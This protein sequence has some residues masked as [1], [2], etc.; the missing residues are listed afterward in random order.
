MS[1]HVFRSGRCRQQRAECAPIAAALKR[2][3]NSPARQRSLCFGRRRDDLH[4]LTRSRSCESLATNPDNHR[5]P[6]RVRPMPR[7][8]VDGHVNV[9]DTW[10]D[11]GAPGPKTGARRMLFAHTGSP[12][13]P[14]RP[15]AP[16]VGHQQRSWARLGR[17]QWDELRRPAGERGVLRARSNAV[18]HQGDD[19]CRRSHDSRGACK[20]IHRAPLTNSLVMLIPN[21]GWL[22][23]GS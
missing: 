2:F 16:R 8:V 17:A 6:A 15:M 21:V 14:V 1:R 13:R 3:G 12:L 11:G 19:R 18:L 7:R 4:R 5:I 20:P 9:A 23:R 22:I 10:R